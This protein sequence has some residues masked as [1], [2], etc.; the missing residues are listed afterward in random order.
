[1]SWELWLFVAAL[2]A[3]A[4]GCLLPSGWLPVLPN[5]KLL[6][7]GAFAGLTV[8]ATLN[9]GSYRALGWWVLGLLAAGLL[10]EILQ[11]L[12]PGRSF[13][14]RDQ[15]ANVAGIGAAALCSPLLLHF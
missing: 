9:A 11:N 12:V 13:C 14:W 8:L 2:A 10:I 5:D 1:M 7:F 6:H 15:A 4:I 3:V